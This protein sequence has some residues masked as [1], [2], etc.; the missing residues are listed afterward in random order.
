MC[1]WKKLGNPLETKQLCYICGLKVESWEYNKTHKQR[2]RAAVGQCVAPQRHPVLRTRH[3]TDVVE[4]L[5]FFLFQM[6]M[7]TAAFLSTH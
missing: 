4:F 2:G 3:N 7:V 6:L 1:V 5:F